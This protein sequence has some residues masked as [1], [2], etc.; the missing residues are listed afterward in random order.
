M[1]NKLGVSVDGQIKTI[2]DKSLTSDLKK[3]IIDTFKA[4]VSKSPKLEV[5][6]NPTQGFSLSATLELTKD[7]K[8]KPPQLKGMIPVAIMG[9]GMK[10][11]TINLKPNGPSSADAGMNQK[12]GAAQAK[13]LVE[14]ILENIVPK[15]VKAMESRVP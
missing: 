4:A 10:A 5:D 12:A 15:A 8:S 11:V 7:E 1:A 3:L 2:F 13:A 14:G 6:D 9:V